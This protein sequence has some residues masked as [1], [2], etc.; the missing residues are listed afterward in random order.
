MEQQQPGH[1][2]QSE[3]KILPMHGM[4]LINVV[5]LSLEHSHATN[6]DEKSQHNNKYE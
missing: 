1:L 2:S 6:A 5:Q 3:W 4:V